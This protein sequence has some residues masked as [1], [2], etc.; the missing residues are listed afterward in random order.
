M[1]RTER[2]VVYGLLAASFVWGSAR[3]RNADAADGAQD[4]RFASLTVTELKVVDGEGH[5]LA[6]I[7]GGEKGGVITWAGKGTQ[8]HG[9]LSV[10][11]FGATVE[12]FDKD[13][14]SKAYIG[15][16]F[17]AAMGVVSV[18]DSTGARR[19]ALIGS[20]KGGFGNFTNPDGKTVV[21]VGVASDTGG[22]LLSLSS[23]KDVRHAMVTA[24]DEG[25]YVATWN[26]D[27]KQTLFAGTASDSSAGFVAIFKKDGQRSAGIGP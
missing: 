24:A 2:I 14:K 26:P 3:W 18:S 20:D 13:G 23:K 9:E 1:H 11:A 27:G 7:G 19:A 15:T 4:G 12:A 10:N 22:G 25:G 5:V 6:R 8:S 21:Y 17:D 16:G